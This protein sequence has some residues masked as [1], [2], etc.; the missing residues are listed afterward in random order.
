MKKISSL[1][2]VANILSSQSR[3]KLLII[4]SVA[5]ALV[6]V[7]VGI[8]IV[9]IINKRPVIQPDFTEIIANEEINP[10]GLSDEELQL[11]YIVR[12]ETLA[13]NGR[14]DE[15]KKTLAKVG[16][17]SIDDYQLLVR[18]SQ[19]FSQINEPERAKALLVESSNKVLNIEDVTVQIQ[20]YEF[21]TSLQLPEYAEKHKQKAMQLN[22]QAYE[23]YKKLEQEKFND[24]PT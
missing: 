3:K 19:I 11:S 23:D 5:I 6:L 20:A 9:W 21:Y 1:R 15:A 14:N 7:G 13:H 18:I 24:G 2:S 16:L 22:P 8:L 10:E 17:D 4:A 12:A